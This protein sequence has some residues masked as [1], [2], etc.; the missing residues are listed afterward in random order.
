[1]SA[2]QLCQQQPSSPIMLIQQ[3]QQQSN[4]NS[5][6][7]TKDKRTN[8]RRVSCGFHHKRHQACPDNCEGRISHPLGSHPPVQ[9][10]FT[11]GCSEC[12]SYFN[13]KSLLLQLSN[14]LPSAKRNGLLEQLIDLPKQHAAAAAASEQMSPMSAS[15]EGPLSPIGNFEVPTGASPPKPNLNMFAAISKLELEQLNNRGPSKRKSPDL[16]SSDNS[17]PNAFVPSPT[18][19]PRLSHMSSSPATTSLDGSSSSSSIDTSLLL[20]LGKEVE[21]ECLAHGDQD[22][23]LRK[24]AQNIELEKVERQQQLLDYKKIQQHQETKR[25][26]KRH[27]EMEAWS[28][29]LDQLERELRAKEESIARR[30]DAIQGTN[31]PKTIHNNS[32]T[33]YHIHNNNINTKSNTTLPKIQVNTNLLMQASSEFF[34]FNPHNNNGGNNTSSSFNNFNNLTSSPSLSSSSSS[35]SMGNHSLFG[36]RGKDNSPIV[37]DTNT[38]KPMSFGHLLNSQSS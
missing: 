12:K 8:K 18:G 5:N 9:D 37:P 34:Q 15:P 24:R 1:M 21:K 38:M 17:S 26:K 25:L 2:S 29:Q 22:L 27:A 6:S 19:S 31:S 10:R 3:Q 4:S 11:V 36:S 30:H 32:W 7:S 16:S 20:L 14:L 33:N 35:S 28:V 13:N 23:S